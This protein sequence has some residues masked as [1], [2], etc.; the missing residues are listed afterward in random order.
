MRSRGTATHMIN[1]PKTG[2]NRIQT[3]FAMN[4]VP[5]PLTQLRASRRAVMFAAMAACF[6]G[7]LRFARAQ[8]AAY[9]L[10]MHGEPEWGPNFSH[11]TYANPAA[12]KGGQ[13]VHGVLGTFDCL[14]PFI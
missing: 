8:A 7:R 9:A 11:P 6:G 12:P 5:L 2:T 13:L 10:A 14:N 1:S 4:S 3:S